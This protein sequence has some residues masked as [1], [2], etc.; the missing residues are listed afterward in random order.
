MAKHF[1]KFSNIIDHE[2]QVGNSINWTKTY[3]GKTVKYYHNG[4]LRL[5][6]AVEPGVIYVFNAQRGAESLQKVAAPKDPKM[7]M[8]WEYGFFQGHFQKPHVSSRYQLIATYDVQ[9]E[10]DDYLLEWNR[11]DST[12]DESWID[13]TRSNVDILFRDMFTEEGDLLISAAMGR[14]RDQS[15]CWFW[16]DIE[17]TTLQDVEY[18][19]K[20]YPYEKWVDRI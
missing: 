9:S 17:R 5:E 16:F 12:S 19:F 10:E 14:Y 11:N 2:I 1:Q 4:N 13:F 8:F 7:K 20:K 15:I 18:F 6:R 3:D